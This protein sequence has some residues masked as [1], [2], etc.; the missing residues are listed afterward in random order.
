[1]ADLT[2]A[3]SNDRAS[4]RPRSAAKGASLARRGAT[5]DKAWDFEPL[6]G[7]SGAPQRWFRVPFWLDGLVAQLLALFTPVAGRLRGVSLIERVSTS[8]VMEEP[9]FSTTIALRELLE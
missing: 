4:F 5:K 1:M 7:R 8:R 6:V 3:G 2:L 9:S